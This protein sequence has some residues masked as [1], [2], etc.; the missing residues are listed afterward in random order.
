MRSAGND[1]VVRRRG[2][3]LGG[4]AAQTFRIRNVDQFGISV[5][6]AFA[7]KNPNEMRHDGPPSVR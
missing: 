2:T 4:M 6:L 7:S 5:K 3:V 1:N